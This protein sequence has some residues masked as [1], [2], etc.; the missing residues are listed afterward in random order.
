M[1]R[2]RNAAGKPES[3]LELNENRLSLTES[4]ISAQDHT[5]ATQPFRGAI[6]AEGLDRPG[7]PVALAVVAACA[8]GSRSRLT[9]RSPPPDPR[10][11]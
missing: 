9:S 3:L 1:P 11:T 2:V 7:F 8:L 10:A 6:A 5:E 4:E